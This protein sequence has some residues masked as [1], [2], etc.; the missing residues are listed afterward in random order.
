MQGCQVFSCGN[1][2]L[3]TGKAKVYPNSSSVEKQ[4]IHTCGL[5]WHMYPD[6]YFTRLNWFDNNYP[7]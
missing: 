1:C 3:D 6:Y 4:A 7:L 5:H 2:V